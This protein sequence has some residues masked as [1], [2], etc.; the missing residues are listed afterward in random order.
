MDREDRGPELDDILRLYAHDK[1]D[2]RLH[3]CPGLEDLIDY[4]DGD[5][6][7]AAADHIRRHM[8]FC[9]TCQEIALYFT[10][11]PPGEAGDSPPP[12]RDFRKALPADL[13]PPAPR[14]WERLRTWLGV[15]GG[16]VTRPRLAAAVTL[17]AAVLLP[18]WLGRPGEL[19]RWAYVDPRSDD[20]RAHRALADAPED[21]LPAE[22]Q[23]G[24]QA[25]VQSQSR[26]PTW[27]RSARLDEAVRSLKRARDLAWASGNEPYMAKCSFYLGKTFL[28]KE[29]VATARR[30]FADVKAVGGSNAMVLQKRQEADAILKALDGLTGPRR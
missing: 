4:L 2:Q 19:A 28:E 15:Q 14:G 7:A 21:P 26:L 9:A 29:D 30:H 16:R 6:G 10:G 11:G 27:D 12:W 3:E 25:L 8:P 18:F 22:F 13:R 20:T 17:V 5:L 1:K 23:K 24:L